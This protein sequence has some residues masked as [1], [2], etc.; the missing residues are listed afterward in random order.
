ME[1][2]FV[3]LTDGKGKAQLVALYSG[4]PAAEL[5][6]L[7]K[8]VFGV[9]AGEAIGFEGDDGTAVPIRVACQ[10][11]EK[12]T[13][14]EYLILSPD[15]VTGPLYLGLLSVLDTFVPAAKANPQSSGHASK[16]ATI[17]EALVRWSS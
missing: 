12:L 10:H 13:A 2:V 8:S 4:L 6:Q 1:C 5:K 3:K 9:N 14:D 16:M 17:V 15:T 7:L 11:P